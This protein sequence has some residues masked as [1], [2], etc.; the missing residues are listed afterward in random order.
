MCTHTITDLY[1]R[2]PSNTWSSIQLFIARIK[3][4]GEKFIAIPRSFDRSI[5]WI[6]T[7]RF[8]KPV[9]GNSNWLIDR[10]STDLLSGLPNNWRRRRNS[11]ITLA[12]YVDGIHSKHFCSNE[13]FNTQTETR[14]DDDS[15]VTRSI[16]TGRSP[17]TTANRLVGERE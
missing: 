8:V 6:Y 11:S 10:A 7:I 2:N 5:E 15:T 13:E 9:T 12:S 3:W 14:G 4:E 16:N 1:A 17:P